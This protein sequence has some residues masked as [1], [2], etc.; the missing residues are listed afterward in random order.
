MLRNKLHS[1]TNAMLNTL[2][3]EI[4]NLICVGFILQI[5]CKVI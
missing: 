2:T 3:Y 5:Y 1:V 4:I